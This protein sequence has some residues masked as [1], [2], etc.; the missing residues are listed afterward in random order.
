MI[1]CFYIENK[2]KITY[3]AISFDIHVTFKQTY[4]FRFFDI[5]IKYKTIIDN[6]VIV[7]RCHRQKLQIVYCFGIE[8]KYETT[9]AVTSFHIGVRL[10]HSMS[11]SLCQT[12]Y[13]KQPMLHS[14]CCE[15]YVR[16][17]PS[18]PFSVG[19]MWCSLCRSYI[20]C[21]Y[22]GCTYIGCITFSHRLHYIGDAY[23]S[24]AYVGAAYVSAAYVGA[25]YVS[26][27]YVEH[28][29]GCTTQ[30]TKHSHIGCAYIEKLTQRSCS[31]CCAAYVDSAYVK[32]I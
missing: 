4:V 9:Q 31:L 29:I 14:L 28:Y 7:H 16:N 23:V 15:A 20:G 24:A 18:T 2:K 8:N 13:V 10:L 19:P 26:A 11:C 30:A 25:A 3:A 6:N 1:S 21:T 22:I 27:A 17:L 12:A 32:M 5:E